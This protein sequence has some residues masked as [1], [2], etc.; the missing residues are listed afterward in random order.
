NLRGPRD[1]PSAEGPD[2]ISSPSFWGGATAPHGRRTGRVRPRASRLTADQRRHPVPAADRPPP[3]PN[4]P[5]QRMTMIRPLAANVS[6]VDA[7]PLMGALRGIKKG[8]VGVRL[9]VDQAGMEG[10]LA[11]A[12]NEVADLLENSTREFAR[13]GRVVGKEGKIKQRA[14][15]GAATGSWAEWGESVNTLI[16]DLVQPTEEVARVIGAVAKGDLSQRIL[17]E[18]EG[19]PLKGEFLRIGKT[20]NRM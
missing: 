5:S 6:T 1:I 10:A 9:P 15:F 8:D 11:E 4:T 17:L 3:A 2:G 14:S 12:L 19:T 13:I 18:N 7:R 16:G 20:V